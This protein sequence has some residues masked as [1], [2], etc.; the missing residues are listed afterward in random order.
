MSKM[1]IGHSHGLIAA[2]RRKGMG[3]LIRP[4]QAAKFARRWLDGTATKPEFDPYVVAGLEILSKC[5]VMNIYVLPGGC[6]L[7]AAEK[8]LQNADAGVAWI[9]NVSDLMLLTAQTNRLVA[10]GV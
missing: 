8:A 4:E 2:L 3:S 6:P 5:R 1:C 10:V 9:D 7:C